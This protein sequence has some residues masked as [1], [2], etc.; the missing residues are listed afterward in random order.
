MAAQRGKKAKLGQYPFPP[1]CDWGCGRPVSDKTVSQDLAKALSTPL[2]GL[3]Q[4]K[5]QSI[6][7]DSTVVPCP[8]SQPYYS[9]LRLQLVQFA[10]H[11]RL[12][13]G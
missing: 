2:Q 7:C 12:S 8:L 10:K 11:I 9:A 6:A 3:T 13:T 5:P 4:K 1:E